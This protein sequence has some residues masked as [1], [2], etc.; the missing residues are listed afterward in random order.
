MGVRR[1]MRSFGHALAGLV[2]M[3]HSE[4]NA[5]IHVG[6]AILVVAGGVLFG[7]GADEWRWLVL[8]V[9]LVWAG[10]AINTAF[11]YLWKI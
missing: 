6:I 5:R 11:E 1:L 7:L 8:A 3:L 2:H 10:E 9:G 4:A